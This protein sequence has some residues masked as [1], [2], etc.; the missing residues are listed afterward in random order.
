MIL[1]IKISIKKKSFLDNKFY[2]NKIDRV[3]SIYSNDRYTR[4]T[5]LEIKITLIKR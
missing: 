1:G 5:I 3:F 4:L 2:E